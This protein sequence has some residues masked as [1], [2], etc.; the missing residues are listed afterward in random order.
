MY[1]TL[2]Q[3]VM[4]YIKKKT[5]KY[6]HTVEIKRI[7]AAMETNKGKYLWDQKI[8][9]HTHAERVCSYPIKNI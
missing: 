8:A 2:F 6:Q 7:E 3:K 9:H 1:T 5:P 4:L